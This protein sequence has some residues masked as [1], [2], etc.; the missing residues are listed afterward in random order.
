[1][2]QFEGHTLDIACGALRTADR[3]LQLRPKAFE[4]LRYLLENADRIVTKQELMKTVWPNV[5]VTD[6]ALTHCVGEVRQAIGDSK[7]TIIKNIPRRGYRFT[8]PVLQVAANAA[9]PGTAG[10]SPALHQ[11]AGE[12]PAVPGRE[13]DR[14]SVAVLPFANLS[15]DPQQDYLSDGITE[16][17]TTELSRFSELRVIARNSSFQYKG[18]AVDIRQVGRELNAR[19][20]LEGSVRWSGDRIRIA[21]QLTPFPIPFKN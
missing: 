6:Q 1:M 15:G 12:T 2:F 10:V 8:A 4:V 13:A 17:I 5:I 19:Y 14:P 16:D 9:A 20:V 7:Q 21:A 3:E 11:R 18:K